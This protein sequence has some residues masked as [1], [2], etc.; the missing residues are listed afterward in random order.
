MRSS[1]VGPAAGGGVNEHKAIDQPDWGCPG[2][3]DW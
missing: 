3:V 1:P 2:F